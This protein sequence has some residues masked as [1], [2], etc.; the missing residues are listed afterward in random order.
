M[1]Q[2]GDGKHGNLEEHVHKQEQSSV[3]YYRNQPLKPKVECHLVAKEQ[4][5]GVGTI[6]QKF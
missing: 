2:V 1:T 3:Y 5:R 6:F 4:R